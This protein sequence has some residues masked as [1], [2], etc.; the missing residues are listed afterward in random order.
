MSRHLSQYLGTFPSSHSAG[1]SFPPESLGGIGQAVCIGPACCR[2]ISRRGN[3]MRPAQVIGDVC[4]VDR[5]PPAHDV[6]QS[7]KVIVNVH[8]RHMFM[9]AALRL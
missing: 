8:G 4:F 7:V 3:V 1:S 6:E 9:V 2:D 5:I